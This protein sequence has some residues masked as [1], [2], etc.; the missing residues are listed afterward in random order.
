MAK[1]SG[2]TVIAT[3]SSEDKGKALKDIGADHVINYGQYPN[4]DEE[5]LKLVRFKFI[6]AT[7][8]LIPTASC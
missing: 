8:I 5:V 4:W 6:V 7:H 3:T 1:A 2:A